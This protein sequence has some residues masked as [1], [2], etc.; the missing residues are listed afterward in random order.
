GR[1][2]DASD[3]GVYGGADAAEQVDLLVRRLRRDHDADPALAEARRDGAE[4]ALPGCRRELLRAAHQGLQEPALPLEGTVAHPPR[5]AH[6]V[7]VHGIVLARLEAVDGALAVV[8]LHVAAVGAR[9]AHRLAA[10]E[11][12]DAGAKA[13]ITIGQRTDRA[14][15]DHAR[16]VPVVQRP[17]RRQ[18]AL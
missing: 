14:D 1:P 8:D 4:R 13:K 15:V 5:V 16:R 17:A 2:G 6:P 11:V 18:V 12:P 9:P 7:L 10:L 3:P